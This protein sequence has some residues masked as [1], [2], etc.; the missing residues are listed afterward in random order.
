MT[1]NGYHLELIIYLCKPNSGVIKHLTNTHNFLVWDSLDVV[2]LR[3]CVHGCD[4]DTNYFLHSRPHCCV[5]K[6]STTKSCLD[7]GYRPTVDTVYLLKF[8]TPMPGL[9]SPSDIHRLTAPPPPSTHQNSPLTYK[10]AG[11]RGGSGGAGGDI[12][13]VGWGCFSVNRHW[14][15]KSSNL[16]LG[17]IN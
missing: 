4:D 5:V 16:F 12:T 6:M 14:K 3:V 13:Q 17:T 11:A 1:S 7:S 10:L 8:E 2:C 9:E 15:F